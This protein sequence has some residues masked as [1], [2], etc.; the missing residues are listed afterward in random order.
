MMRRRVP[1]S[2][3]VVAN[4]ITLGSRP[5]LADEPPSPTLDETPTSG[6]EAMARARELHE[7]GL[8]HY[9]LGEYEEAI[10]AFKAA[11]ELAPAS[12]LLF[13]IAQAYRLQGPAGCGP[14]IRFYRTFLQVEPA[15]P[16]RAA[17][18]Q[19]IA[20]LDHCGQEGP[21]PTSVAPGQVAAPAQAT[22][23]VERDEAAPRWPPLTL[24]AIGLAAA[25]AGGTLYWLAGKRFH[26]LEDECGDGSCSPSR[27]RRYRSMERIGLGMMATGGAATITAAIWA[28]ARFNAGRSRPASTVWLAP[29]TGGVALGG[30]F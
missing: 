17:V 7:Q 13:N 26:D 11:Y 27:W 20:E 24:G 5:L 3:F 12:G 2:W 25:G 19:W 23:A 8:R 18:E 16:N 15:A 4:L 9:D 6:D 1:L 21:R 30:R 29:T 10:L 28:V 14:A 22:A